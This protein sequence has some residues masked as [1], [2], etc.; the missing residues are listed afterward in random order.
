MGIF[1]EFCLFFCV[2]VSFFSFLCVSVFP[3]FC[4]CVLV[5]QQHTIQLR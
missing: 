1:V 3:S 5:R 4:F 2:S